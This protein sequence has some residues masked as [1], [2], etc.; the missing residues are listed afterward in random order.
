[1]TLDYN[2]LQKLG[3]VIERKPALVDQ[4]KLAT[5]TAEDLLLTVRPMLQVMTGKPDLRVE[6]HPS[7]SFTDGKTVY[8][9]VPLE[10]GRDTDHTYHLCG[11]RDP[12]S[13]KMLCP[14]CDAIDEFFAT[15]GHESAHIVSE[16]FQTVP[17]QVKMGMYEKLLMPRVIAARPEVEAKVR[18]YIRTKT[19]TGMEI[20]NHLDLY[21]PTMTNI[22]EDV[23][24]NE[25][26]YEARPGYV[27]PLL[28]HMRVAITEGTLHQDGHTAKWQDREAD[29]RAMM[30]TFCIGVRLDDLTEL[31]GADVD[32]VRRDSRVVKAMRTINECKTAG[33]RLVRALEV[34][35]LLREH[36]FCIDSDSNIFEPQGNPGKGEPQE[37]KPG[38]GKPE[39]A[40]PGK[41]ESESEPDPEDEGEGEGEGAGDDEQDD[42]ASGTGKSSSGES[43]PEAEDDDDEAD[44]AGDGDD[45]KEDDESD[46]SDDDGAGKGSD[47]DDDAD[48][49]DEQEDDDDTD[50]ESGKSESQARFVDHDSDEELEASGEAD[51]GEHDKNDG[52]VAK[53]R[54]E[55]LAKAERVRMDLAEFMGHPEGEQEEE[56]TPAEKIQQDLLELHL[57]QRE[58]FD[59]LSPNILGVNFYD[60]ASE[61]SFARVSLNGV[62]QDGEISPSLLALRLAFT[63][64][65][66]IGIQ[67]NLQRGPRLDTAHLHRVSLDDARIFAARNV[68]KRRDWYVS[69]ALDMSGS[70]LGY[71]D[72]VIKKAGYAIGELLSR[73]GIRFSIYGHTG[74][75]AGLLMIPVKTPDE[76]WN[77][78]ARRKCVALRGMSSNL[79]GHTLEFHRKL[80]E[81]ERATD[82]LIMYFTDGAMPAANYD[83]ELRL[84]KGN[85]QRCRE[86]GIK[87]VGVGCGNDDPRRHGLDTI[88]YNSIGDLPFLVSELAKRLV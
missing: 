49:D 88:L 32:V 73:L 59:D 70:T 26:L 67:R 47:G 82:K 17:E 33:D 23:Y 81:R 83:E 52:E 53:H 1:M 79:D 68:P 36:G 50:D 54:L 87:L 77:D 72:D 25:D 80:V 76:A 43:E 51:P 30:V 69:L 35:E 14:R 12:R 71:W 74:N 63:E 41:G 15:V 2:E 38:Q 28:R 56:T 62:P 57:M 6:L 75:G 40:E 29:A 66:K 84:L 20:A 42:D 45:D 24:V 18:E 44:K 46:E 34:L 9:R 58:A 10:L 37:G 4:V 16:S 13:M 61:K 86:K 5:A 48:D 7:G 65:R 60:P 27:L 55:E 64:N 8:I 19:S 3:K 22:V 31:L 11:Q 39:K 85:I 21:L 78:V